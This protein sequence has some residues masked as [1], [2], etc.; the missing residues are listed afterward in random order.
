MCGRRDVVGLDNHGVDVPLPNGDAIKCFLEK[1]ADT[2]Q[3][4]VLWRKREMSLPSSG[5]ARFNIIFKKW[6]VK[7]NI[8]PFI[9]MCMSVHTYIKR[10]CEQ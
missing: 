2:D 1:G 7:Q 4:R 10:K 6:S 5:T 9:N 3:N 8:D